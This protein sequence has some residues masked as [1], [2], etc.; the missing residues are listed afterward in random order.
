MSKEGL[1]LGR[2]LSSHLRNS[3]EANFWGSFNH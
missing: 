2:L 3:G 1:I